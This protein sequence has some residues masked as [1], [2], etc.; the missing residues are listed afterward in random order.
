MGVGVGVGVAVGV[1][2]GVPETVVVIVTELL[3]EFGSVADE[4]TIDVLLIVTPLTELFTP[5][6]KVMLTISPAASELK[7]TVR[8]LPA[9]P[10]TPPPVAEHEIKVT[11]G[12]SMSVTTILSALS[13][14]LFVRVIV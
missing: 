2:V 11:S 9:P 12:G 8:L 6:T 5:V 13:G 14:P 10:Q 4:L 7:V 3:L 1:G